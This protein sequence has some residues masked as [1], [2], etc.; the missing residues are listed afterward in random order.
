MK[1]KKQILC[2][3]GITAFII[4]LILATFFDLQISFLL[5]DLSAGEM[6]TSNLYAIIF[7][8]IG[9]TLLYLFLAFAFSVTFWWFKYNIKTKWKYACQTISCISIFLTFYYFINKTIGY[10]QNY[11]TIQTNDYFLIFTL[12]F[13]LILTFLTIFALKF[14]NK[15]QINVLINFA[16]IIICVAAISNL[17]TQ[18]S[19]AFIF[20][21]MRFRAMNLIEDFS[22]YTPWF[23]LNGTSLSETLSHLGLSADA[24][25]SFP[26]GHTT[27]VAISFTL[28]CL[29][30]LYK[31]FNTKFWKVFCWATPIALIFIVGLA[32][33]ISGAHFLSDVLMAG[34]ITFLVTLL[35]KYIFIDLKNK[36]IN[37]KLK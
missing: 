18:I 14:F 7:E 15:K 12:F 33:I 28:I 17:I 29:P 16:L 30:A 31:K 20:G 22:Y 37:N 26:S 1:N 4:I 25:K 10:L 8:I 5:S 2:L 27:A 9:E 24:F 19:K 21:R 13:A 6:L 36:R 35:F 23:F 32:R 34:L 11:M 3:S